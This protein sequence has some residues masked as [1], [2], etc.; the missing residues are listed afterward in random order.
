M[1]I[2]LSSTFVNKL[3]L[4]FCVVLFISQVV[5]NKLQLAGVILSILGFF[6]RAQGANLVESNGLYTFRQFL[7][8]SLKL[9]H[10]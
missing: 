9:D 8:I 3:K 10:F 1:L 5:F 7:L 6:R 4:L 2:K